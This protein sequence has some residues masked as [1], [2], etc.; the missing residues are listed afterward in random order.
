MQINTMLLEF[1]EKNHLEYK[2]YLQYMCRNPRSIFAKFK[3]RTFYLL[4]SL[5]DRDF[6][7]PE[8]GCYEF[9]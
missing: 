5:K 2:G 3:K 1:C 9:I 4:R 8:V 6:T 7:N